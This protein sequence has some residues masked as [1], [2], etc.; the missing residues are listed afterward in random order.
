LVVNVNVLVFYHNFCH[1]NNYFSNGFHK[2]IYGNKYPFLNIWSLC[3]AWRK[4]YKVHWAIWWIIKTSKNN[5]KVVTSYW[6]P[7]Q[8]P[9][10]SSNNK[11]NCCIEGT[12]CFFCKTIRFLGVMHLYVFFSLHDPKLFC[13]CIVCASDEVHCFLQTITF[14]FLKFGKF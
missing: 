5:I 4:W 12:F 9:K 7:Y 13:W 3:W 8:K 1:Q 6:K 14:L 2:N 10:W 11:R